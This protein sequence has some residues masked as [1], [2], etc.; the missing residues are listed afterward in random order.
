[1]TA[2]AVAVPTIVP[3]RAPAAGQSKT[4]V[5]SDTKLELRS[6]SLTFCVYLLSFCII[7]LTLGIDSWLPAADYHQIIISALSYGNPK[8]KPE[9]N[10]HSNPI[11]NSKPHSLPQSSP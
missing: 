8:Y 5:D 11:P 6:G 3:L 10:L 1:M 9:A 2:G 4:V 7:Y